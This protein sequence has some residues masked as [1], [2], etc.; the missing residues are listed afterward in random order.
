MLSGIRRTISAA[1]VRKR[2]AT[3]DMVIAMSAT[4]ASL[5]SLRDRVIILLGFAGPV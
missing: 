2:A 3:S 1:P 5:H 4:G